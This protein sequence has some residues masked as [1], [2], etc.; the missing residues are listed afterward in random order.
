MSNIDLKKLIVPAVAAALVISGVL[1][2]VFAD[3][4]RFRAEPKLEKKELGLEVKSTSA[5]KAKRR[6][7]HGRQIY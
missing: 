1:M 5:R 7:R 3:K 2:I 6:L 4:Y